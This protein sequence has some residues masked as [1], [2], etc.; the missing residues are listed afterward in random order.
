MAKKVLK[1]GKFT[2]NSV[3]YPVT[4]MSIEES[5]DEIDVTDTG[6]TGDGKEF[7]G[8]RANRSFSVT[9][10]LDSQAADIPLST[11]AAG[12]IDFEGKKYA[13]QMILLSKTTEG[14]VDAGIQQT[15]SGRF[16]GAVTVTPEP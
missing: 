10:W 11:E 12:E 3:V 9:V 5:F 6:T 14:S 8:G 7:L 2:F 16:N 1:T 4:D 15:Y 13:G